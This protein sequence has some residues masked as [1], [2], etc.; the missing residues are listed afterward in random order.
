MRQFLG[1]E[2]QNIKVSPGTMPGACSF[3]KIAIM[4][5]HLDHKLKTKINTIAR[6]TNQQPVDVVR[7]MIEW[8]G[9][10]SAMPAPRK[11]TEG[12]KLF[13][14]ILE[15]YTGELKD[16]GTIDQQTA[17]AARELYENLLMDLVK[18]CK[19][20]GIELKQSKFN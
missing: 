13:M 12:I 7:K 2:Q 8:F 3:T 11:G 5:L 16:M 9:T 18:A 20:E 6:N 19:T 14:V 4:H 1:G 15:S 17:E 10:P